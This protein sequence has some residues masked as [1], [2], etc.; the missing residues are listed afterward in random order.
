MAE[1]FHYLAIEGIIGAGKTTLAHALAKHLQGKL[2][3]EEFVSNSF[4]DKFYENPARYAFP[5]EVGFLVE[6]YQQL[7]A[8]LTNSLFETTIIADY[9]IDKSRI[10]AKLN[11]NDP[12]FQVYR[13]LYSVLTRNLPKP[14]RLL[15]LLDEPENAL[16]KIAKRGRAMEKSISVDYLH[17]LQKAYLQYLRQQDD[18]VVLLAD[19]ADIDFVA[20][21]KYMLELQEWAASAHTKGIHKL[22]FA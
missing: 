13:K 12:H 4:L 6:R 15:Y 9:F 7:E 5:T 17:A 21:P 14:D 2:I 10:F 20:E 16:R 22:S 8:D 11:L 19:I 18:C 3:L 1:G